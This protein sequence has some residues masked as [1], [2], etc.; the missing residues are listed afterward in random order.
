MTLYSSKFMRPFRLAILAVPAVLAIYASAVADIQRRELSAEVQLSLGF[1]SGKDLRCAV[2]AWDE[3]G[4]E[5]SCGSF[6]WEELKAGSALGALK[7]LAAASDKAAVRDALTVLLALPDGQQV[8]RF[9][10]DWARRQGLDP[11]EI[12]AARAES[13]KLA[14]RWE[15][16]KRAERE[17]FLAR[18]TP[19][20]AAFVQSPWTA[21]IDELFERRTD[22]VV[23]AARS[24]LA[25]AGGSATLHATKHVVVFAESDD[26][27]Y[28]REAA[29]LEAVFAE[30]SDRLAR[31]GSPV[32]PQARIPVVFV[33]ERDRWRQLVVA[34][35]GGDPEAHPESVTVYL[36]IAG[37]PAFDAPVVLIAP[38]GDRNRARYAAFVGLSRAILHYTGSPARPPAFLNEGLP[39]VMADVSAP[40]AGMDIGLRRPALRAIRSGGSFAPL[41]EAGYADEPWK[42]QAA[43]SQSLSYIFVRWLWDNDPDGVL[44]LAKGTGPWLGH[45]GKQPATQGGGKPL[46]PFAA[47]FS[48]VFRMTPQAASDRA[49]AWF[50][51]ND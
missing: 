45:D 7:A 35:F 12:D 15:E 43:L 4:L 42:S 51:T 34:A 36:P 46:E 37:S 3:V 40:R 27:I 24:L 31:S 18:T 38:E 5:G 39:R 1:A 48:R 47:R 32:V 23:E 41:F 21:P 11:Q 28:R 25:R 33:A 22:A 2:K 30:W 13:V 19:E 49:R 50:R 16:R 26:E 6:R 10:V 29:A 20:G 17:A 9:A 44:R 8:A 14:E